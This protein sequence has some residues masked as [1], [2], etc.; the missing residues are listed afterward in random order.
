MEKRSVV[1]EQAKSK[2]AVPLV[3]AFCLLFFPSSSNAYTPGRFYYQGHTKEKVIALTFD[4]GPGGSTPAILEL[5]RRHGIHATFF[6]EGSQIEEYPKTAK[7]VVEEGHEVGN[8]TY[9]HFDFHKQKNAAAPEHLV[10]ELDQTEAALGR[11]AGIHTNVVRMPYGYFNHTWLLPTLKE[12]GYALVHWSFGED[13][14]MKKTADE[15]IHDYLAHAQPGAV[16]LFHDGG[17]R[18]DKTVAAVTA[19]IDTLEKR[20]YRFVAAREM[21]KDP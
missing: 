2:G 15:L 20:G 1:K 14:Q 18:R 12:H 8:H 6:M 10:H 13:W 5:L 7:E 11:A 19:V 3:L 9:T 16:F 4:D 21:F 17:R